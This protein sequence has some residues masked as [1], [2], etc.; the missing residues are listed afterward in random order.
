MYKK[1]LVICFLEQLPKLVLILTVQNK[2]R[3]IYNVT[4]RKITFGKTGRKYL[5]REGSIYPYNNALYILLVIF[6]YILIRDWL[7]IQFERRMG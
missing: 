1:N 4:E 6:N 5:S 7:K 2:L 3:A